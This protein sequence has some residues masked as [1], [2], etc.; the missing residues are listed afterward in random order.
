MQKPQQGL[1]S[2]CVRTQNT[3]APKGGGQ[4][5]TLSH[6]LAETEGT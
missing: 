2:C 1:R 4:S 5:K 3:G 6:L